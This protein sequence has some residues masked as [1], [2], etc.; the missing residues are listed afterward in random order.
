MTDGDL[1]E[2]AC[3][4]RSCEAARSKVQLSRSF[5]IHTWPPGI[6]A[7]CATMV[8]YAQEAENATKAVKVCTVNTNTLMYLITGF[9]AKQRLWTL[10]KYYHVVE[11]ELRNV[12]VE[13]A[14]IVPSDFRSSSILLEAACSL[15][16]SFY[17]R[18]WTVQLS[19]LKTIARRMD[20]LR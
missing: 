2:G 3:R 10:R 4:R 14:C 5:A 11:K 8:K 1:A 17:S 19:F 18:L 12:V 6:R 20:P 16:G 9:A 13:G 7:K 15:L